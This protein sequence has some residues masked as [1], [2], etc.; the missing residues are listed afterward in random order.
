[1]KLN[2]GCQ[3]EDYV[4]PQALTSVPNA[5]ATVSKSVTVLH[6]LLQGKQHI[7]KLLDISMTDF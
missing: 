2:K 4:S 7:E 6:M 1:M 3:G 5:S